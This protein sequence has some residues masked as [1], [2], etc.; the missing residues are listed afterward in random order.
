MRALGLANLTGRQPLRE[1]NLRGNIT[2][3][4]GQQQG[5]I[6]F[7]GEDLE[8]DNLNRNNP[9]GRGVERLSLFLSIERVL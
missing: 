3:K 5:E 2:I 7:K 9:R 6:S 8:E 4:G 1:D